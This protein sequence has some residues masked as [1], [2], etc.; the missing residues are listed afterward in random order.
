MTMGTTG[1]KM[2]NKRV[3]IFW[4]T[5]FIIIASSHVT[6]VKGG[7]QVLFS[8]ENL[9]ISFMGYRY[10]GPYSVTTGKTIHVEWAADRQVVVQILN[11]I[12][13]GIFLDIGGATNN[14]VVKI[15]ES[16]AL[17]FAVQYSDTFY[18]VVQGLAGGE[19]RLYT[20]TEKLVWQEPI[21][22]I[23]TTAIPVIIVSLAVAVAAIIY[24]HKKQSKNKKSNASLMT[25]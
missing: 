17:E 2:E 23:L 20:W 3:L 14:R 6:I 13:W 5:L 16:G 19:A 10:S 4:F 22:G 1:M 15:S 11:E 24:F 12:D 8:G 9:D 25:V 21:I 7:E 18:I